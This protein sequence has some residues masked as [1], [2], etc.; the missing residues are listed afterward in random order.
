M[1]RKNKNIKGTFTVT[2]A[3]KT[4]KPIPYDA[5]LK[6]FRRKVKGMPIKVSKSDQ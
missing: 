1:F 2:L 4:S 3:G 6:T 5:N